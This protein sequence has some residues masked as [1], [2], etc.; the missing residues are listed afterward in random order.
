[1]P[2]EH[3]NPGQLIFKEGEKSH[4]AYYLVHGAVEISVTT[5]HGKQVLG[6]IS[7]GEV[8]GGLE[9]LAIAHVHLTAVDERSDLLRVERDR[10]VELGA[11][12]LEQGLSVVVVGIR[13][14]VR[15]LPVQGRQQLTGL[16]EGE[17]HITFNSTGTGA[18]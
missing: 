5:P 17:T 1:M 11:R 16:R 12:H 9:D 10:H 4:D 14:L 13:A 18:L 7:P 15:R 3:F 8:F 2:S 6:K